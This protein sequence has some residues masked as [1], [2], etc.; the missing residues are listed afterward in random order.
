MER[1]YSKKGQVISL[2][3]LDLKYLQTNH[4]IQTTVRCTVEVVKYL[5]QN[6]SKFIL[7]ERFCQNPVEECFGIQRQLAK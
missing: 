3:I 5:L 7:T 2:K 1:K 6:G 4:G